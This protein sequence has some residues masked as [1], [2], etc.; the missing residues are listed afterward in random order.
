MNLTKTVGSC[1]DPAI[2]KRF[3]DR[4]REAREL[5]GKT[6][7]D[8][9]DLIPMNRQNYLGIE[10]GRRPIPKDSNL[11]KIAKAFK[12]L[13]SEVTLPQIMAWKRLDNAS[14]EEQK[15][16]FQEILT[17]GEILF[18]IQEELKQRILA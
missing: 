6:Q 9:A 3:K 2:M 5:T 15:A 12:A 1:Y 10:T 7:E 4:L 18:E 16:I 13:G 8:F 17:E 11:E 14:K